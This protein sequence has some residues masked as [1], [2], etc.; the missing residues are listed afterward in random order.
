MDETPYKIILA[1]LLLWFFL[2]RMVYWQR[3]QWPRRSQHPASP[4][5][6]FLVGLTSLWII[7][8]LL[9]ISTGWLDTL[10]VT[11]PGWLR[12]SGVVLLAGGVL[13][14]WYSHAALGQS[15]S[16][17]IQ[18][19]HPHRLVTRGP[20][21]AVR[22]PMYLAVFLTAGGVILLTGNWLLSGF[23]LLPFLALYLARINREEQLLEEEFGE[24][25]RA[26]KARTGK[27]LPRIR[28]GKESSS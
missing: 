17:F 8:A 20:Y 5:E 18:V 2:V 16:P 19:R 13:L 3:A 4:G 27:L 12:K 21:A 26:Y 23:F 11:L 9:Y 1:V 28:P 22:H 15:L 14:Y 7:P 24:E 6:R 25:Y 10:A